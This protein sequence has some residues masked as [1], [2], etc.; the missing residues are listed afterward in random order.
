[1]CSIISENNLRQFFERI[2]KICQVEQNVELAPRT[3]FKTGGSADW[4]L[5]PKSIEELSLIQKEAQ[6][7]SIPLFLLGK[8]ANIL[9]SDEGM[10][11][12]VIC[13]DAL[14]QITIKDN[15]LIAQSGCAMDDLGDYACHHSLSGL[16]FAA[17]LPGTVGGAIWMNARCYGYSIDE[18]LISV[19]Y[20]D[21]DGEIQT[22]IPAKGDFAYKR[23][24][25]QQKKWIIL[26]AE[27]RMTEESE[28]V[29]RI[30][31]NEKIADRRDK[32]HFQFPCAGSVFKNNRDFGMPSGQIIDGLN[33][34]GTMIGGAKISDFHANIIINPGNASS[35]DILSLIEYTQK[36]VK[37]KTGFDLEPE[38]IPVGD[39]R[40]YQ[41][42]PP[43]VKTSL[44]LET[45]MKR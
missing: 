25:F 2:N 31:M 41:P 5:T 23:S 33:L 14:N 10:R 45:G 20:L 3:T 24:P 17:G 44:K 28:E 39:W 11:E 9:V 12:P 36:R 19:V 15:N 29:I 37:K 18:R 43:R 38:V 42:C 26:S 4:F 13:M 21:E 35:T 34:R 6:R 1:M 16:E 32:G 40:D 30:R 27:F 8:G 7:C 22:L